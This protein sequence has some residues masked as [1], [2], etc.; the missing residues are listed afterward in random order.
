MSNNILS[1]SMM[2]ENRKISNEISIPKTSPSI[3][4]PSKNVQNCYKC[5]ELFGMWRRKHHC[6]VCGRIFCGNCAD[7]WGIIPSLV[8]LTSPVNK[9]FS[10]YSYIYTEKRMCLECKDKIDFIN[11]SLYLYFY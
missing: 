10:L 4:I 2:V 9:S 6:R 8:N 7:R 5:K 3:W 1:M 11:E